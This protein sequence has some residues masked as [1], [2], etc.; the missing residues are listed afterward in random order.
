MT[1][2]NMVS[3]GRFAVATLAYFASSS[4]S[5]AAAATA[6]STTGPTDNNSNS[7]NMDNWSAG[8]LRSRA[9]EA[10]SLRQFDV[11]LA[12]YEKATEIEPM[13]GMNY[14]KLYKV[15]HRMKKFNDALEDLSKAVEL[16]PSNIDWRIQKGKLLKSLGQCD[17]AVVEYQELATTY[18]DQQT[19]E[20]TILFLEAMECEQ[21]IAFAQKALMEEDYATAAHYF[22]VALSY[23]EVATDLLLLKA[24]A[25]LATSDYY[26]VI[27]DTGQILKQYPQHLEAYRLRGMA[28]YWLGDHDLAIKHFREGLK[29]DPEHKGCKEGH[30]RVK[31]IDKKKKRGDDAFG[32][33]NFESAIQFYID[34]MAIEP[35]HNNFI[36]PTQMLV[37]QAYSKIGKHDEALQLAQHLVEADETVD[38]LWALG[39][40]LTTAERY[41]EALRAYQRALEVAPDSHT[42]QT[43]QAKQKVREAEVALKQSKEKNY[44]KILGLA[45]TAT[46]KEIKKAYRE[47]AM[48]W[49]PDKNLERI[50]E[51]EKKFHDIGEAYEV[52]SN[53]ETKAKYDRGEAVFD[54][55]GGGG[56]QGTHFNSH[57]FFNQHFAGQAGG[58]G[59]RFH[60]KMG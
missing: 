2:V 19:E 57:Q 30:K 4:T 60:F 58:G 11:A 39:E 22:Q 17:R 50:E 9:E 41:D 29:L 5:A 40:V 21:T 3:I 13:N 18:M 1:V 26:G 49:H 36:R 54:N 20:V 45:R 24:T 44:Y 56:Q 51:A 43:E 16:D 31:Q 15:H 14:Y 34:A 42:E 55:Q 52:L 8:K 53:A 23:V 7:N 37:I 32:E 48:E 6:A 47:L 38:A 27:S 10:L 46:A 35:S 59:Q 25:L 33:R 12:M 28:Y